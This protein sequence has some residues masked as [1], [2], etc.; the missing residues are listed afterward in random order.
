M[1]Q[2]LLISYIEVNDDK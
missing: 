1:Y 2:N